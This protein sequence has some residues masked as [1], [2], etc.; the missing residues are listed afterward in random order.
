MRTLDGAVR[1]FVLSACLQSVSGCS[2][3]R[4]YKAGDVRVREQRNG[5]IARTFSI[6]VIPTRSVTFALPELKLSDPQR[7][8]YRVRGYPPRLAPQLRLEVFDHVSTTIVN[9]D[10]VGPWHRSTARITARTPAGAVLAMETLSLGRMPLPN[11][12]PYGARVDGQRRGLSFPLITIAQALRGRSDYDL[13]VAV[14]K[15]W[16]GS[17]ESIRITGEADAY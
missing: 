8:R 4:S 16:R 2:F 5:P 9:E 1:L 11:A 7:T 14:E 17:R 3:T 12:S 15:P 13:E 6:G 10:E